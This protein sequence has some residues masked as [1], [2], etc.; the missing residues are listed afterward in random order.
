MEYF[1]MKQ[2][3]CVTSKFQ[4]RYHKLN[5]RK[6][7]WKWHPQKQSLR[8]LKVRFPRATK[9]YLEQQDFR[10]PEL[11]I[12]NSW[13]IMSVYSALWLLM[14]WCFI[15]IHRADQIFIVLDQIHAEMLYSLKT[16]LE[17]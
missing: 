13:K 2:N 14:S 5:Y 6:Q 4:S 11:K 16:T 17:N 1:A 10:L 8:D 12:C 15:S 9:K 3:I 7:I